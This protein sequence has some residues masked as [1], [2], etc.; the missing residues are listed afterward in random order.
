MQLCQGSLESFVNKNPTFRRDREF[1]QRVIESGLRALMFIAHY[2][3]LHRDVKPA[4]ILYYYTQTEDLQ[5]V[6][7]DFT[8]CKEQVLARTL[9]RGSLLYMAPEVMTGSAPQTH[10]LDV[11]SLG[12]TMLVLGCAG[13]YD[14]AN[15]QC[16]QDIVDARKAGL[17]DPMFKS[18]KPILR[19]DPRMRLSAQDFFLRF[20][21]ADEEAI[22]LSPREGVD[23]ARALASL[24]N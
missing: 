6:L 21:R 19:E 16:M 20:I 11:Y 3:I 15:I 5:F 18:L 12:A 17:E 23:A 24:P 14:E 1:L 9:N 8:F 2:G 7:A 4:N 10:K 22:R 13:G